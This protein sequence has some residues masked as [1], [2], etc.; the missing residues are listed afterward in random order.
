[1]PVR[2][3]LRCRTCASDRKGSH[4]IRRWILDY[5]QSGRGHKLDA[6]W[7]DMD[8]HCI[9]LDANLFGYTLYHFVS[10]WLRE[11][12]LAIRRSTHSTGNLSMARKSLVIIRGTISAM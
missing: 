2:F 4:R 1:M 9:F 12:V 10:V 8:A 6:W 11:A 7:L 3:V 5:A